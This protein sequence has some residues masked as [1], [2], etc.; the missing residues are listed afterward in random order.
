MSN[1]LFYLLH[2]HIDASDMSR[3]SDSE[4]ALQLPLLKSP[5]ILVIEKSNYELLEHRLKIVK[6]DADNSYHYDAK[7]KQADSSQEWLLDIHFALDD[8][9]I[10]M[11]TM[12]AAKDDQ[13]KQQVPICDD[14]E[15]I[16]DI[17]K[18]FA[19]PWLSKL[20]RTQQALLQYY[21]SSVTS[22]VKGCF[23]QSQ[24]PEIVDS[25][26]ETWLVE[27][28]RLQQLG[29]SHEIYSLLS[30]YVQLLQLERETLIPPIMKSAEELLQEQ[31]T[32]R[33][34]VI[35]YDDMLNSKSNCKFN[36]KETDSYVYLEY[37]MVYYYQSRKAL[38]V[39]M[40]LTTPEVSAYIGELFHCIVE[41][42]D[43]V[44]KHLN[45][46]LLDDDIRAMESLH[47]SASKLPNCCITQVIKEDNYQRLEWLMSQHPLPLNRITVLHE[48]REIS[49]LEWAIM[50][51][52]QR[53]FT[54]LLE[55]D[56]SPMIN[57]EQQI[58]LAFWVFKQQQS[59]FFQLLT[60]A[61]TPEGLVRYKRQI[62]LLMTAYATQQPDAV[63]AQAVSH[64]SVI[65]TSQHRLFRVLHIDVINLESYELKDGD[66]LSSCSSPGVMSPPLT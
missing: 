65:A 53:C 60:D 2:N 56:V 29:G 13:E 12:R 31:E 26:I 22:Q 28:D 55:M 59:P 63:A 3:L 58:P 51:N 11:P 61:F 38:T 7:L 45:R 32:M 57:M 44:N 40:M 35:E 21:W 10:V 64:V 54:L 25:E 30:H 48:T 33:A 6:K 8:S 66:S 62:D 49:L 9:L 1:P 24:K 19:A 18:M 16:T 50:N 15:L 46:A 20:H 23:I 42:Y 37:L 34:F 5:L 43:L 36:K 4:L 39:F 47:N 41:S 14:I 17:A 52:A 27:A